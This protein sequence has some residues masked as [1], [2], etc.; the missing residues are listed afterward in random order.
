[1]PNFTPGPW[2]CGDEVHSTERL[3]YIPIRCGNGISQTNVKSSATTGV[4]GRNPDGTT[5]GEKYTDEFGTERYKP[6]A[7][8]AECRANAN[9]IA[10]APELY[11][12]LKEMVDASDVLGTPLEVRLRA[13]TALAKAES[14]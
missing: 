9:L 5:A 13:R 11:A 6:T 3:V 4:Y 1:M 10:A 2:K 14:V 7:T 8:E 12:A